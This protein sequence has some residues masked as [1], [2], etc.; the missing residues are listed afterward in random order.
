MYL[1]PSTSMMGRDLGGTVRV[2]RIHRI[3]L[4]QE[5]GCVNFLETC[6]MCCVVIRPVQGYGEV[7]NCTS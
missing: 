6:C 1:A 2:S 4:Q 3:C 7:L 5:T